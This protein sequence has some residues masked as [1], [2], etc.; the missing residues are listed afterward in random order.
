MSY[1]ATCNVHSIYGQDFHLKAKVLKQ[2]K[3]NGII[4]VHNY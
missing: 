4:L 3:Y 1:Q 2:T